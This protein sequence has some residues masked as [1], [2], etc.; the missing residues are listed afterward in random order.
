MYNEGE[1]EAELVPQGTLAESIRSAGAG[2]GAFYTPTSVGTELAQ[3]KEHRELNGRI[4][5]L[6]YGL[7]ADYAFIRPNHHRRGGKRNRAGGGLGPGPNPHAWCVREPHN[8]DTA[9]R[10]LGLTGMVLDNPYTT[11]NRVCP[12]IGLRWCLSVRRTLRR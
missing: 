7:P 8:P 6:E 1:I 4:H 3:E 12:A 9:G 2:I 11:I 5:V 10:N